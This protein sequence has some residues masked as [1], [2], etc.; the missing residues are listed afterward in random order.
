MNWNFYDVVSFL[1][2]HFFVYV[3]NEGSHRYYRGFVD[4]V[5][6]L[7][8]IQYHGAIAIRPRTLQHSIIPKSGVPV[9]IWKN[10]AN[11]GNT[12]ARRRIQYPRA[13]PLPN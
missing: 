10:W 13:S 5:E 2:Q 4:G 11:A 8:E 9:A 3:H 1:E 7:V 6:R 12:K